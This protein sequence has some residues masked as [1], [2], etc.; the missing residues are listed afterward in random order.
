MRNPW[1]AETFKGNYSDNSSEM[2]A[3]VRAEL[4]HTSRND[5]TFWMMLE[6]F[7][8]Q[9]QYIGI[10]Y[11]TDDWHHDYFLALNDNEEGSTAG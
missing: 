5:G 8:T 4:D 3:S 6:H 2:T 1:G 11:D 9:V 7:K 10:N